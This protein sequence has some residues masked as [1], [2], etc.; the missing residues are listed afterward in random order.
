[1][2]GNKEKAKAFCDKFQDVICVSDETGDNSPVVYQFAKLLHSCI[3]DKDE[4]KNV[5]DDEDFDKN[6]LGNTNKNSTDEEKFQF[7]RW[8]L[9][10]EFHNVGVEHPTELIDIYDEIFFATYIFDRHVEREAQDAQY[11][12]MDKY[13]MQ[14]TKSVLEHD[15]RRE[16]YRSMIKTNFEEYQPSNGI[17]YSYET[18]E[19]KFEDDLKHYETFNYLIR[20]ALTSYY[21]PEMPE[22]KEMLTMAILFENKEKMIYQLQR[23]LDVILQELCNKLQP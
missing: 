23:T 20:C 22:D 2:Y 18:A 1:M 7:L 16:K 11:Q 13:F 12:L 19:P 9:K 17:S 6:T 3:T 5:I 14:S 10:H 15:G 4:W 8:K 21:N